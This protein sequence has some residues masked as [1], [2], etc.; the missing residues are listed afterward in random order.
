MPRGR[1]GSEGVK[2]RGAGQP[3]TAGDVLRL[4]GL[5]VCA[6]L[7]G[8]ETEVQATFPKYTTSQVFESPGLELL[9]T[10]L[11]TGSP[12]PSL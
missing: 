1:S 9:V 2:E 8:K 5:S 4:R 11:P 10:Q 12:G 6:P 3:W 7:L